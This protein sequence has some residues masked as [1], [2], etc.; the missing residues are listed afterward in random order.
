MINSC[1]LI[2]ILG[3]S[4]IGVLNLFTKADQCNV[5]F[6]ACVSHLGSVLGIKLK[7]QQLDRR[8]NRLRYVDSAFIEVFLFFFFP[9]A[10]TTKRFSY[11]FYV[12]V[13]YVGQVG[14][15]YVNKSSLLLLVYLDC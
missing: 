11:G 5:K 13:S 12:N 8:K 6:R 14:V 1:L 10:R 2:C 7:K 9:L 4:K 3:P 15:I